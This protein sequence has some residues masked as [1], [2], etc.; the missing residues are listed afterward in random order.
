MR[1]DQHKALTLQQVKRTLVELSQIS[2]NI[3]G[4]DHSNLFSLLDNSVVFNPGNFYRLSHSEAFKQINGV[5]KHLQ[6]IAKKLNAGNPMNLVKYTI[7]KRPDM[8]MKVCIHPY[9]TEEKINLF[10]VPADFDYKK[11]GGCANRIR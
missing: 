7:D 8:N 4:E 9:L 5:L 11:V 1:L 10:D 3:E 6:E 2:R